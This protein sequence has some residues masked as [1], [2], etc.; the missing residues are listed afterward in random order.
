M[1]TVADGRSTRWEQHRAT[2][3]R[4]LV[5]DTLRAIRKYGP[6][7]GMDEIAAVAKT[8]K[9]VFYRHFGDRLGLYAAVVDATMDYILRNLRSAMADA[10]SDLAEVVAALARAYLTLVERDPEIYFFVLS[11]PISPDTRDAVTGLTTR[12]G[13]ELAV[14][15]EAHLAARGLDPAPAA[16]WGHGLVGFIRAATDNWAATGHTRSVDE[17]VDDIILGF[18]TAFADER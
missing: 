7:V 6:G 16:T 15:I 18:R 17:V 9:S 1:S 12:I 2:R 3:R 14:A 5:E 10:H 11:R 13:D 4:E 8:S